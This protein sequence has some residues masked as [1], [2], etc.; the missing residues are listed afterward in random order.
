MA[1]ADVGNE[2]AMALKA[3]PND[4]GVVWAAA[5]VS[6]AIGDHRLAAAY[7]LTAARLRPTD[8]AGWD[9]LVPLALSAGDLPTA[10]FAARKAS[11]LSPKDPGRAET[12]GLTAAL[13]HDRDGWDTARSR[14]ASVV[15]VITSFPPPLSLLMQLTPPEGLLALLQ[16]HDDTVIDDQGLLAIRAQMRAD[17][18]LLNEAARDGVLL[19]HRHGSADGIALSWA[20][21]AGR[22]YS[23][24]ARTQLDQAAE[25]SL[26]ARSTRME[27]ALIMGDAD[28]TAD[29][30]DMSDDPRANLIG[31]LRSDPK[32]LAAEVE[33]WPM[34]ARSP[35][36]RPPSGYRSNR[37]LGAAPGLSAVSNSETGT[38][39]LRTATLTGLLP[40]PLAQLYTPDEQVLV[41]VAGGTV[42]RLAG[43]SIPLYLGRTTLGEQDVLALGFSPEAAARTLELAI[44]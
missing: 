17:A 4:P 36:L 25:T 12:L 26:I 31:R 35:Y 44:R 18:G 10:G 2:L 41:H 32:G 28:P 40:A 23:T 9:A 33:G 39:I 5:E 29:A 6:S 37:W 22:M 8:A 11:D 38:A 21:T 15:P 19:Y 3:G 20:A 34:D 27:A 13:L 43:G 7:G 1:R 14:Q 24:T 16:I 42:V 30:R